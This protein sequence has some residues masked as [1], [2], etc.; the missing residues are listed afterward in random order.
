MSIESVRSASTAGVPELNWVT[1]M[2]AL[3]RSCFSGPLSARATRPGACVMFGKTPK[4]TLT[5]SWSGAI[6]RPS[7]PKPAGADAAATDAAGTLAAAAPLRSA[8]VAPEP[9]LQA[10]TTVAGARG[11]R[12][13]VRV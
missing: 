7:R 10:A 11:W 8:L 1:V 9:L 2:L 6:S 12:G 4:R 13:F 3:G 5:A